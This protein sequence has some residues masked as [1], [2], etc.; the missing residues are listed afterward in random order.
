MDPASDKYIGE[1]DRNRERQ[2]LDKEQIWET[3]DMCAVEETQEEK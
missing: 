1:R 2:A 3:V